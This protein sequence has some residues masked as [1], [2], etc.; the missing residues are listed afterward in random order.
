MEIFLEMILWGK[1]HEKLENLKMTH[2][3]EVDEFISQLNKENE[4]ENIMRK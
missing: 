4:R 1:V 2:I 3:S